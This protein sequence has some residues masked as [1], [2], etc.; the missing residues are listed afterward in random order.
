MNVGDSLTDL[1]SSS[2]LEVPVLVF[3]YK[4]WCSPK[5]AD[6]SLGN[7]VFLCFVLCVVF[8]FFFPVVQLEFVSLPLLDRAGTTMQKQLVPGTQ[9]AVQTQKNKGAGLS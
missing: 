3:Y 9:C 7:Y 8:V 1:F 2:D 4:W 6:E 5:Q